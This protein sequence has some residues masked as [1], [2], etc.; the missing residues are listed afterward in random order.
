MT[1]HSFTGL[2]RGDKPI[3][4]KKVRDKEYRK[5]M[6]MSPNFYGANG[7]MKNAEVIIVDE[8]IHAR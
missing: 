1:I 6:N 7:N 4:K 8:I 5:E 3:D 2:F